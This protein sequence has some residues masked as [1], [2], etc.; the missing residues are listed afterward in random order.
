[1]TC[2]DAHSP[3]LDVL[4]SCRTTPIRSVEGK[5]EMHKLRASFVVLSFALAVA[6]CGEGAGGGSERGSAKATIAGQ[7]FDVSNVELTFEPGEDGYFRI[8]GDDAANPNQD[9]VPGLSGGIAL[10]GDVPSMVTSLADLTGKELPFEFSGDGDDAN[11]CFVGSNGLLGV[12]TGTVR[13]L[14]IQGD[15]VTF[16]FSGTFTVYDGEG[17][18]S[19]TPV[20]GSGTG[21]AYRNQ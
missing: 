10:Y 15:Q 8:E 17:G 4:R 3:W 1:M 9:C 5:R 12:E 18:E 20:S 2:H 19:P 21:T 6:S 14:S 11:L 16:S 13:F 7:T